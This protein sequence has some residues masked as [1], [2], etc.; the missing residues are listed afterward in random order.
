PRNGLF[1]TRSTGTRTRR[2]NGQDSAGTNLRIY[3][4]DL[5]APHVEMVGTASELLSE[6]TNLAAGD[7]YGSGTSRMQTA[8]CAALQPD[9]ECRRKSYGMVLRN[10]RFKQGCG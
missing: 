8:G 5:S 3:A 10:P 1:G 2:R 9:N 7:S 6:G 4:A